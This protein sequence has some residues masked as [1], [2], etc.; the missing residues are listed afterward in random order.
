MK[1][2]RISPKY[3]INFQKNIYSAVAVL[4]I[5]LIFCEEFFVLFFSLGSNDGSSKLRLEMSQKRKCWK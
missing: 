5:N 3:T 4:L 1:G 2:F